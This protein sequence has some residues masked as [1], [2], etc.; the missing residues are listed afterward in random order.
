MSALADDAAALLPALPGIL[1]KAKLEDAPLILFGR[2]IGSV[3][4]I[5]L[6]SKHG[7]AFQVRP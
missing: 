5:H 7:D 3:C 2:S 1:K 4:A 6:A